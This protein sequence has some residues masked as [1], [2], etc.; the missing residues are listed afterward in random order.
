MAVG[1][2][3]L[4]ATWESQGNFFGIRTPWT[5]SVIRRGTRHIAWAANSSS[6]AESIAILIEI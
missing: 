2:I 6:L 5:L 1:L 4:N 3:V